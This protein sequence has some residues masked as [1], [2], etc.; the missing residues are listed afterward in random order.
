VG[1]APQRRL[2]GP[3]QAAAPETTADAAAPNQAEVAAAAAAGRSPSPMQQR[4]HALQVPV[5]QQQQQH[6]STSSGAGHAV[7]TQPNS[8]TGSSTNSSRVQHAAAESAIMARFLQQQPG[9]LDSP[10]SSG[11]GSN[12]GGAGCSSSAAGVFGGVR[13]ASL[14]LSGLQSAGR[15]GSG[16][17]LGVRTARRTTD[18]VGERVRAAA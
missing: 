4:P 14:E 3:L 10:G 8:R 2:G 12:D 15:Q 13:S 17:A 6:M 1:G 7:R 18:L 16:P 5:Q 11:H 9:E